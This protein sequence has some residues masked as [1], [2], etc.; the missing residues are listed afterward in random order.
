MVES[1]FELH[2]NSNDAVETALGFVPEDER[3]RA[4]LVCDYI[5]GMTDRYAADCYVRNV[6]PGAATIGE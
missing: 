6:L 3:H 5:A 4:R 1:L 2:M